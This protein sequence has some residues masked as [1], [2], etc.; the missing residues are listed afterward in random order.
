MKEQFGLIFTAVTDLPTLV[1]QA[2]FVVNPD[3]IGI[4]VGIRC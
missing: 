2:G 3:V 4:D 1:I